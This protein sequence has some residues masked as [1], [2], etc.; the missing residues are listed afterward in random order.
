MIICKPLYWNL[1]IGIGTE[2]GTYIIN[3]IAS[4][5]LRPMAPALSRLV[6]QDEEQMKVVVCGK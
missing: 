3:I 4:T 6:T 1:G 2:T 5:S